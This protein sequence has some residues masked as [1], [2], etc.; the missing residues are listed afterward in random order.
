ML[1]NNW[2]I[3]G[4]SAVFSVVC[5]QHH[6][7]FLA[8]FVWMLYLALFRRPDWK[9]VIASL[10]AFLFF[11]HHFP[12][13]EPGT[14]PSSPFKERNEMYIGTIE[15]PVE[16]T[17]K[18]LEFLYH[19]SNSDELMLAYHFFNEAEETNDHAVG[20]LKTGARCNISGK[21]QLPDAARNPYQ[22]DYRKYL[23]QQGI[24]YQLQ[25]DSLD[26]LNCEQHH[27]MEHIYSL[28]KKLLSLTAE[29]LETE[30][31]SWAQALVFGEDRLLEEETIELFQRWGLSHILAISGLHIGIVVG[32]MYWLLVRRSL[33]TKENA[34]WFIIA[35]LPV[36]AMLA[37]GQPSVW[38]AS[39]MVIFAIL[40][41]KSN[42]RFSYSD[43]VNIIFLTLLL[44]D[45]YII[46]HIGFQ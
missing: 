20:Q 40:L 38:R 25:I 45:E 30:T 23:H 1:K 36:Y 2:H 18:R 44:M 8:Y 17:E 33:L 35:F 39:S 7:M 28:R 6:F 4:L 32:L 19:D 27:F 22:F 37:G 12:S 42:I 10:F 5:L 3:V 29:R 21:K 31:A 26:E 11:L 43:I 9:I 24:V 34:Q 15:G 41:Q 13:P 14:V 16:Q 46:Y